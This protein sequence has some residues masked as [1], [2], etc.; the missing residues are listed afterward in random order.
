VLVVDA[1]EL[2]MSALSAPSTLKPSNPL[3]VIRA[4]DITFA[5]LSDPAAAEAVAFGPEVSTPE[6][7]TSFPYPVPLTPCS[8]F[9]T[10]NPLFLT[11]KP[12]PLALS[13]G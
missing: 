1:S 13:C 5:M 3:K 6:S 9:Q 7:E 2:M 10:A 4:C 11:A 12:S 8:L